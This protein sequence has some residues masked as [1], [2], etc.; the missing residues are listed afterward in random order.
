MAES[1]SERNPFLAEYYGELVKRR[2]QSRI[3]IVH[4]SDAFRI[5][6]YSIL[7]IASLFTKADRFLVTFLN[8]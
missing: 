7:N 8:W 5:A 3:G 4:F 1:N 2:P 6:K